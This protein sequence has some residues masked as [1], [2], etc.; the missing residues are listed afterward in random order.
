ME[1]ADQET[2]SERFNV[3]EFWGYVDTDILKN[4]DVD[5]PKELQD[6]DQV[7][8]NIWICNGQVLRLVMNPFTPAI[9]PYY[10]V[11][12]EGKSLLILWCRYC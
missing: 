10:A 3:L 1:D 6:Q 2:R 8:V 11:P 5:I 7:S 12:F 9:L 4:Y